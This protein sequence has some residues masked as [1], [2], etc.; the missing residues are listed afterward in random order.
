M[1][2]FAFEIVLEFR[3]VSTKLLS[4]FEGDDD[5][6][7]DDEHVEAGGS[8]FE[9]DDERGGDDDG[10]DDDDDDDGGGDDGDG[11]GALEAAILE[12]ELDGPPPEKVG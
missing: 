7:D 6:D 12:D 4:D 9:D 5:D 2:W 11:I 8:D 10:G 1:F 3:F